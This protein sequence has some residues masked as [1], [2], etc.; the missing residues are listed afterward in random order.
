MT[1]KF[2]FVCSDHTITIEANSEDEAWNKLWKFLNKGSEE[3]YT[4]ND[5]KLEE[6]SNLY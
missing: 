5:F 4:I 2:S 6:C 3:L 1:E